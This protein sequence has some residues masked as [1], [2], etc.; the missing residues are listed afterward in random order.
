IEFYLPHYVASLPIMQILLCTVGFGSLIQILHVSFYMVYRKQQHY[1]LWGITALALSAMLNLLAIRVWGTLESV[2]IATL[3]SFVMWYLINE[4]SLR[5]VV[6]ESNRELGKALM[7]IC[8]YLGVF[9]LASFLADW[10]IAQ[11]L[12][13]I[14]FFCLVTW[15]LLRPEAKELVHLANGLR[16][17]RD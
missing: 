2:A 13:Y 17:R 8:S 10:F 7:I 11:M 6:A 3:I 9:W 12:I 1:F 16:N 5:S 14:G 15:L 4:L